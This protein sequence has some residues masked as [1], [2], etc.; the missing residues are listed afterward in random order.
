MLA[1]A[2]FLILVAPDASF[3]QSAPDIDTRPHNVDGAAR[4]PHAAEAMQDEINKLKDFSQKLDKVADLIKQTSKGKV[5]INTKAPFDLSG[6]KDLGIKNTQVDPIALL[7]T[8]LN[9]MEAFNVIDPRENFLQP[10]YNPKNLPPLPS[11][12]VKDASL[13][14]EEYGE[15]RG[16]QRDI[17]HAKEFLEKNYIVLK[18]T[19]LKTKRLED[20]ADSAGS[21]SGIAGMYWATVKANPNDPMNKAKAGFYAK[22]DQGQKSGLDFL[23][24]TLKKIADFEYKKYGDRNWYLYFGLPYYNFMVARYTR[25]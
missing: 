3:A 13:S 8:A 9:L 18:Q 1:A 19:E 20:L 2:A 12:A 6:L 10:D 24:E 22:Y 14:P 17:N 16:L 23:N 4:D 5:D 15:F 7:Q 11:R 25:A 21:I